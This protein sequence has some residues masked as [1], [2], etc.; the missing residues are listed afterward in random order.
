MDED[1]RL[2]VK[3]SDLKTASQVEKEQ[4]RA[5][6]EV[7]REL[8]RTALANDVAIRIIRYRVEH[9]LS[10]TQLARKLGMHQPAI[11]RLESGDHEPSLSTLGRLAKGLG[12]EFRINVSSDGLIELLP[13]KSV[14]SEGNRGETDPLDFEPMLAQAF[15][16]ADEWLAKQPDVEHKADVALPSNDLSFFISL[17]R[18]A[19]NEE[20]YQVLKGTRRAVAPA[21]VLLWESKVLENLSAH[22]AKDEERYHFLKEAHQEATPAVVLLSESKADE[23]PAHYHLLVDALRETGRPFLLFAARKEEQGLEHRVSAAEEEDLHGQQESAQVKGSRP[24]PR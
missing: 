10:Q 14:P 22:G 18:G 7:R 6:P 23:D 8:E 2:T 17:A 24:G 12:I 9:G 1:G 16:E 3:L 21:V 11:A 5:D 15:S 20:Y 13:D 4:T 19:R